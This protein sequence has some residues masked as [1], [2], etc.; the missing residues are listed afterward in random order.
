MRKHY[1]QEIPIDARTV[2]LFNLFCEYKHDYSDELALLYALA[3]FAEK[4]KAPIFFDLTAFDNHEKVLQ[5][6]NDKI[7]EVS[8]LSPY[9]ELVKAGLLQNAAEYALHVDNAILLVVNDKTY[10]LDLSKVPALTQYCD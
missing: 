2:Y 3:K 10:L 7:R 6:I 1:V 5:E 4:H 8:E 9:K